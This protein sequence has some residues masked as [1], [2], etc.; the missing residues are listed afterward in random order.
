MNSYPQNVRAGQQPW[1]G[2]AAEPGPTRILAFDIE[3]V[4]DVCLLPEAFDPSRFP[5]SIWHKVVAVAVAAAEI[6]PD[7]NSGLDRY[8]TIGVR[9]LGQ[10]DW[11]ERRLIASFWSLLASAPYRLVSFNGSK[12][13]LPVLL[14]R[15][16]VH[17]VDASAF[18]RR[19]DKWTG[20]G[21]RYSEAWHADL[22]QLVSCQG[23]TPSPSLDELAA[24]LGL[25][26]KTENG[27]AVDDMVAAGDLGRVRRYCEGDAALTLASYL[28]WART[29]GLLDEGG[30]R[31]SVESLRR[32]LEGSS[33]PHLTAF[34]ER[35]KAVERSR[36]E[37]QDGPPSG[38]QASPHTR[39]P[40]SG[41][42][43]ETESL[44]TQIPILTR[45]SSDNAGRAQRLIV[46]KPGLWSA[47]SESQQ[48][49]SQRSSS[50]NS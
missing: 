35:W 47:R 17:G 34:S 7:P 31:A 19:G 26:G 3:T 11:D 18:W 29:R 33:T 6:V 13:D 25:P 5:K 10:P 8:D 38:A 41:E 27:A 39:V 36:S 20:Y 40:G 28:S 22:L 49:D 4:P 21:A 2:R 45:S 50:S 16:L 12:F 32:T 1:R 24:A 48:G 43:G 9:S 14:A 44:V 46:A 30:Y 15:S 42:G 37:W 23:A